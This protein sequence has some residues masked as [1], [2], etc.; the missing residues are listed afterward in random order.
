MN[1]QHFGLDHYAIAGTF[2]VLSLWWANSTGV[3][4]KR[5]AAAIATLG[6]AFIVIAIYRMMNDPYVLFA[7]DGPLGALIAARTTGN[8]YGVRTDPVLPEHVSAGPMWF[9]RFYWL[10]VVSM[11]AC[12]IR[13]IAKRKA[14]Q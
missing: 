3:K 1:H 10:P 14:C 5:I 2:I 11:W 12:V 6:C 9:C 4:E 13:D 7:N 8:Y